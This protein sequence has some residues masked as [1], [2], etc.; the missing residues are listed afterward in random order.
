MKIQLPLWVV[1]GVLAG[2]LY[3]A[4]LRHHNTA[5]TN[6]ALISA[7]P[8]QALKSQALNSRLQ[9]AFVYNDG[10]IPQRELAPTDPRMTRSR[11][12]GKTT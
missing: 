4:W 3:S 1:G 11:I 7:D 9:N 5:G 2:L 8:S 10:Q 12:C 6:N